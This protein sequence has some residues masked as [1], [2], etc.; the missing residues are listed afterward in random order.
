M[1]STTSLRA[2]R[3]GAAHLAS[4]PR[5]RVRALP[6]AAEPEEDGRSTQLMDRFR[7]TGDPAVFEDLMEQSAPMLRRMILGRLRG[8]GAAIDVNDV[9]QDTLFNIYRYP[10]RFRAD[11]PSAFRNW[12][13]TIVRNMVHRHLRRSFRSA[14]GFEHASDAMLLRPDPGPGPAEVLVVRDEALQASASFALLLLVWSSAYGQLRE[15]DRRVLHLIEVEGRAYREAAEL[16]GVRPGN[17]KMLVFR[18][19]RR[20]AQCL[21]KAFSTAE[22]VPAADGASPMVVVTPVDAVPRRA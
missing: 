15:R 3:P 7:R 10:S 19:R 22:E 1:P 14:L 5:P 18:A 17:L 2:S 21:A 8:G 6:R 4:L 9:L 20:I 12:A 13:A 11:R 16:L